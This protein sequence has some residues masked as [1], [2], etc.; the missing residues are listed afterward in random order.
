MANSSE[1]NSIIRLQKKISLLEAATSNPKKKA[2]KPWSCK[3]AHLFSNH[4]SP[5]TALAP[6]PSLPLLAS[7]S[8]DSQIKIWDTDSKCHVKTLLSHTKSVT[9]LQ[10]STAQLAS[11]SADLTVKIWGIDGGEWGCRRT[12][13]GHDE[14]VDGVM[15]GEGDGGEGVLVS[16]GRD[17][18]RVWDVNSGYCTITL[19]TPSWVKSIT[20]TQTQIIAGTT[21]HEL[22]IYSYTGEA[23]ATLIGHTHV[24]EC[25]A[26]STPS[27]SLL[28]SSLTKTASQQYIASGSRDNTIRIWATSPPSLLLTL[29][30]HDNWVRSLSFTDTYLISGSDDGTIRTWD[31][32][33]GKCVGVIEKAH[34]GQFVTCVSGRGEVGFSG[35]EDC[36]VRVWG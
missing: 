8:S 2:A 24:V 11:G 34:E 19:Q 1:N 28:L 36:G 29:T 13:R 25:L 14:G 5:I 26:T 17:G 30:G 6:H 31:L 22:L 32:E 35:G 23:M 21:S 9:C 12:L 20:T 16:C 33:S 10:F 27:T 7:G 4:T 15:W 3:P 18:V